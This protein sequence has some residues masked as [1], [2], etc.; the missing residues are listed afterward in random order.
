MSRLFVSMPF[1]VTGLALLLLI[2]AC[3][4]ATALTYNIYW[5]A[6]CTCFA[7]NVAIVGM[8]FPASDDNAIRNAAAKCVGAQP[9]QINVGVN[10]GTNRNPHAFD[11][12][13]IPC[14]SL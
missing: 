9:S 5:L 10:Y 1:R 13:I 11:G 14:P 3:Y 12:R 4:S 6:G 8:T 2:S 7:G